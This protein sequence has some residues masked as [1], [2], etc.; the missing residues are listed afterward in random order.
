M[1]IMAEKVNAQRL[2]WKAETQVWGLY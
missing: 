2:T 1:Q